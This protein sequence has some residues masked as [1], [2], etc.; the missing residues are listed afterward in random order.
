MTCGEMIA[1]IRRQLPAATVES[2]SDDDIRTEL[3]IGV[4]EANRWTQVYKGYT[5]FSFVPEQQI[6]SLSEYVPDYLGITKTGVW[7]QDASEKFQFRVSKT[8]KWLDLHIPNWRDAGS[9]QPFWYWIDGD[10]LGFYQKPSTAYTVRMYHLKKA[11]SMDNNN[12]Y[13]WKNTTTE[14]TAFQGIDDAI[15]AYARMRLSPAVGKDGNENPLYQEFIREIN[16]ARQQIRRRKDLMADLD[17]YERLEGK[18]I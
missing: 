15:I 16:K 2:I 7:W 17:T 18:L 14:V 1:R 8:I 12:N 11:T 3:N 9:G 13:P 4:N 5:E 10:E 6:Y